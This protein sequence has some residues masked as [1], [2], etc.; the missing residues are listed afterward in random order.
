MEYDIEENDPDKG[1]WYNTAIC[2][3]LHET[4]FEDYIRNARTY[5]Y[6]IM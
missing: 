1:P 5:R 6:N 3:I 4:V 2:Y